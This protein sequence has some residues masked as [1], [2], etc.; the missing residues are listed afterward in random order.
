[1]KKSTTMAC[2]QWW[3]AS[4]GTPAQKTTTTRH[5]KGFKGPPATK[6][7]TTTNH[8]PVT[9]VRFEVPGVMWEDEERK[10]IMMRR[11]R[12]QRIKL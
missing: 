11:K 7:T 1:M 12:R 5:H 6:T 10:M 9:P 2:A 4:K 8:Q 3:P